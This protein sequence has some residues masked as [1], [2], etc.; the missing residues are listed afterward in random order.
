MYGVGGLE[1]GKT[2]SIHRSML[3]GLWEESTLVGVWGSGTSVRQGHWGQ[4]GVICIHVYNIML[5]Q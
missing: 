3:L 2:L 4:H 5:A 1:Q